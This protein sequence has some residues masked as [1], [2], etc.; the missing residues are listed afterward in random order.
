[1]PKIL[2]EKFLTL[3]S[4]YH[5]TAWVCTHGVLA[6]DSIIWLTDVLLTSHATIFLTYPSLVCAVFAIDPNILETSGHLHILAPT[7]K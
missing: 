2:G 3:Q 5:T 4:L 1:M 7:L 6:I